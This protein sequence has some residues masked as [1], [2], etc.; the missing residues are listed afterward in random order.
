MSTAARYRMGDDMPWRLESGLVEIPVQWT[1]EDW[2]QFAFNAD[3]HWG[4]IPE[5]CDKVYRLW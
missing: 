5:E 3:P 4:V 2:E 1:L